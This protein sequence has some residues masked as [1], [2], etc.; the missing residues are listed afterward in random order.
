MSA[1]K[2]CLLIYSGELKFFCT[3][4]GKALQ[5]VRT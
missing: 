4:K 2:L 5:R 1:L 3:W